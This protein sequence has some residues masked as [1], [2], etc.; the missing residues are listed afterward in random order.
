M[1]SLDLEQAAAEAAGGVQRGEV[2]LAEAVALEQRDRERVAERQRG[3]RAGGRRE[4][5]RAGFLGDARVE[6]DVGGARQ[7]RL[8]ARR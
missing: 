8:P 7:R 6:H 4:A 5:E 2:G 3:G 1:R